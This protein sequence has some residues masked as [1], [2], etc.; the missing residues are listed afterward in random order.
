MNVFKHEFEALKQNNQL[1][2]VHFGSL[3]IYAAKDAAYDEQYG[4]ST[5]GEAHLTD[6]IV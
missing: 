1:I 3:T 4:I 6:F 5:Q 2:V